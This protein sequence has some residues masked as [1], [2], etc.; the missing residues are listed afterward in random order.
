[1]TEHKTK[2]LRFTGILKLFDKKILAVPELQREFVWNAK[3]AC[4]LLDSIHKN[5]PIG[6]A[7]IWESAARYGFQLRHKLHVLPQFDGERNKSVYF[8]IDG[9]QRLSVL[10]QITTGNTVYNSYGKEI[11]FSNI[12]FHINQNDDQYFFYFKRPPS[13]NYFRITDIISSRYKS[14]FRGIGKRKLATIKECR[15]RLMSFTFP[16]TFV[17]TDNIDD[18][19]ETFIRINSQGT[20]VSAADRAFARAASPYPSVIF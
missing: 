18:I 7:M 2:E 17:K 10:Y 19:R 11:N 16:I 5:Y 8:L 6:T 14:K 3:K 4:T 13:E 9:Q 15:E 1:M 20:P 12:Y